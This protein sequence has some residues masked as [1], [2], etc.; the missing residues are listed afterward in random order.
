MKTGM[1][2]T[3]RQKLLAVVL[4]TVLV[5]LVVALGAAIVYNLRTYR[6]T[7]IAE[8]ETQAELLGHMT[9]PALS[10]DDK[11]LAMQNL[12]L[13]RLQSTVRVGAIYDA[14]G[15]LF[16]AYVAQGETPPAR[17]LPEADDTRIVGKR[18]LLFE[19]IANDGEILGTVYLQVDYKIFDTALDYLGIAV[20]VTL[21]A[22]LVAFLLSMRLQKFVIG[23]ILAI[24]NI[25]HDVVSRGDYSRRADKTSDDEIGMLV[26]SFNG[27][28]A[29]I[30]RRTRALEKSNREIAREAGERARAQQEVMQLNDELESRVREHTAQLE[31]LNEELV[32]AKAVAESA[33]QAKSAFLSSMSHEL[34]TPLNAILGFAQ[35]LVSDTFRSTAEQRKEFSEHILKAGRHL[36]L[37]INEI[38]D[39][40]KVESGALALSLEPVGLADVLQECR[41]MIGPLASSRDLRTVFPQ[42]ESLYLLADRTRLKQILLNLLSNAVK[43]NRPGGSIVVDCN[44]VAPERARITVQDTGAG[45]RPEQLEQLF[46]PF[47]RLG[48]ENGTEDGTG[49]GLVVTKRLVELMGGRIGA[50]SIPDSGST[51]WIELKLSEAA[52]CDTSQVHRPI[53]PAP[54]GENETSRQRTLLYVEDNPINLRL[55]QSLVACRGDLRLLTASDANLGIDLA[56]SHQPDVIL[57]DINLPGMSGN[58]AMIKLRNDPATAHIPV[59]A[60]TANAMPREVERGLALGFFRY[61]TKPINLDE[62]FETLES[63]LALAGQRDRNNT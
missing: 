41:E 40:A 62:F 39:L 29:E 14:K 30:E 32:A 51:F 38:L 46:Q 27:M 47:N 25:T 61:L 5:A 22:M 3:V 45:L 33:S 6:Q 17:T 50:A 54:A 11:H 36:Q 49:I 52:A 53:R 42:A 48:Q 55:V 43:Y 35:L 13:L 26:D 10:F 58:D 63:A 19:P 57:M 16:A 20:V 34:R 12:G 2:H 44:I 31:M 8:M 59:I 56:R 37:L 4:L 21:I 9:A 23:P 24:A 28:L 1:L 18:L 15:K 60:L 7:V